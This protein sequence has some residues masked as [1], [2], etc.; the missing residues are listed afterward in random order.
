[1]NKQLLEYL[2]YLSKKYQL[3]L[4]VKGSAVYCNGRLQTPWDIQQLFDKFFPM[5]KEEFVSQLFLDQIRKDA[6]DANNEAIK[7]MEE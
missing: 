7:K 5:A 4:E 2:P 3:G 1:M 6:A